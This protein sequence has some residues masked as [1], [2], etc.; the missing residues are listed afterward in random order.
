MTTAT[1]K[2]KV[3]MADYC[4]SFGMCSMLHEG[5]T[6]VANANR[7]AQRLEFRASRHRGDGCLYVTEASGKWS[8]YYRPSE[9]GST[10]TLVAFG[11]GNPAGKIDAVVH[12]TKIIEHFASDLAIT[13]CFDAE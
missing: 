13:N 10:L 3:W 4:E 6:E 12:F 5:E 9:E 1:A 11:F 7:A 2:A 8:G